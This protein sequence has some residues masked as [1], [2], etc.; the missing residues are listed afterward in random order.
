MTDQTIP[1]RINLDNRDDLAKID[2]LGSL[3]S[4]EQLASQCQE[5]WQ[6]GE[7][8]HFDDSYR[9]IDRVVVAGMGGS[10]LGTHI[11]QAVFKDELRLPITVVP[12]YTMPSFVDSRTLV[13]ASSYSGTT[14]ETISAVRDARDKGAKVTGI[15]SG[16]PLADLLKEW[17]V[18][19]LIFPTTFNPSKQPRLG[20]GYSIFGQMILLARAGL[21]PLEQHHLDEVLDVIAKAHLNSG[22]GVP[23]ETNPAKLLAFEMLDRIPVITIAEHL[24]GTAHVFANQLNESAKTYAEYRV[25]PELNHH[26]MEGLQ[27]PVLNQTNLLFVTTHSG[28][29]SANNQLRMTLTE[30]VIEQNH[31]EVRSI[32]LTAS[33][34][35]AQA[36]ELLVFG[37]YTSFYLAMLHGKNPSLIPWVDWFK[38]QLKERHKQE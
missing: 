20:L 13:V 4:L 28:L 10:T 16:G 34:K 15:T 14:E 24:E 7:S 35:L 9:D 31:I 3:A 33:S 21:L 23:A 18:P 38:A 27:F 22:V 37:S 6:V 29:Y 11:I 32:E 17:G 26:L 19:A 25:V 30:E 8:L 2:E 12:D 5:V 1:P 36:F